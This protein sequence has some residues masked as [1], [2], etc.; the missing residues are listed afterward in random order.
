MKKFSEIVARIDESKKDV[1]ILPTGFKVL[2]EYLDGGFLKK[3]FNLIGGGTGKGKSLFA[4]NIFYNIARRGF[5]CAYFS[6]EISNEMLASRLLGSQSNISPTRIMIKMLGD[7]EVKVKNKAK[8]SISVFE[9]FMFFYDDLY[10]LPSFQKEIKENLYDFVVIDF[11]QNVEV[12]R[13][14]EYERLSHVARTLQKMAKETNSC[15]LGLSQL[16][17]QVAR[18]KKNND[19][20]EYRG[21]GTIGHACD[22]GFFIEDSVIEN[23]SILR[24]RKNRRGISGSTFNFLVRQPGGLVVDAI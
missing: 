23:A 13:M 20:V 8:A 19:I 15:I 2:D 3:E 18:D 24:L 5:K 11:I 17:N 7:K 12:P 4:G 14:E 22:L 21:S 6:L 9:E 1:E 16:S 10:T